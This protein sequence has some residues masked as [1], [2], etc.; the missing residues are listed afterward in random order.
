MSRFVCV[1]LIAVLAVAALCVPQQADAAEWRAFWADAWDYGYCNPTQTSAMVDYVKSCNCNALCVEMRKRADSYY[2]SSYEP[3]GWNMTPEAGYDPLADIV[4]KAHAQGLE[5]HAWVVVGRVWTFKTDP[6]VTNPTHIFVTHP[7]W[8]TFDDRGA[9]FDSSQC[10]WLDYGHPDVED[11]HT[12]VFMEMINNYNIDGFHLDYIRYPSPDWG[13]NPWAIARYN[14]EYGTTGQPAYTDTRFISWRCDQVTNH[15]KRLYLEAK[16]LKPNLK[17]GSAA[18]NTAS[19]G[20][21]EYFQ[22]WNL[23]MQQHY[24]DYASP[25]NYTSTNSTFNSRCDDSF[26]RQY[27]HHIYMG[28]GAYLNT[29]DNTVVQI[30]YVQGKPFPGVIMYSYTEP[31]T[32]NDQ[33]ALKA[34]LLGGPFAS[35]TTVPDMPWI[36][37][38]TLGMLKGLVK[39]TF[40]NPIYPATVTVVG[41]G[42]TTK[43]SG[44]GFYGLVDLSP[45]TYTVTASATGYNTGSQQVTISAGA[46]ATLNFALSTT[47]SVPEI[48]IDNPAAEYIGTWTLGTSAPDKYGAD[49]KYAATARKNTASAKWRPNI[50]QAGKYD[51][52]AW[53]PQ[54]ANNSKVIPFTTYYNGGSFTINVNQFRNGGKWNK[55]AIAK[56]FAVGTAGYAQIANNTGE[57]GK[58]IAA[59]AVKFVFVGL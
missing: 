47:V 40:G 32:T 4:T 56:P 59:D 38:P 15:V 5:V 13:Y 29:P 48:I 12:M 10:S 8:F 23:W 9:K 43:N 50:V 41:P 28:Q 6:P 25:M 22:D 35:P 1:P 21:T 2:N 7:E 11:Y 33:A 27:G 49:Y 26:N 45:A 34:A 58:T 42:K 39:D 53:W 3:K 44:T 18:W 20:K 55:V 14:A 31:T 36:S 57:T 17:F 52:Y 16:A 19:G 30:Q 54:L 51:V 24:L 46:V 37:S